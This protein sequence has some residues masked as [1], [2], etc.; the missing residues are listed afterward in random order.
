V[1]RCNSYPEKPRSA[2]PTGNVKTLFPYNRAELKRIWR[3]QKYICALLILRDTS[4]RP[5]EL[6]A[7]KWQDWNP[8]IK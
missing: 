4:L 2:L 6:V 5:G 7:L 8:E 3:T 1:V